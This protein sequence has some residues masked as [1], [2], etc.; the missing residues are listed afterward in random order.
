LRTERSEVE[1]EVTLSTDPKKG[2]DAQVELK[3]VDL[4]E[5]K[6]VAQLPWGGVV[7][8]TGTLKGAYGPE[9]RVEGR[10]SAKD[11]RFHALDI[12]QVETGLVFHR[13]KL[14]FPQASV[15][16]GRSRFAAEGWI[17]F[18]RKE[19]YARARATM[20]GARVADLLQI[21]GDELWLFDHLR[22]RMDGR[23]SGEAVFVEGPM[24]RPTAR[25]NLNLDDATYFERKLGRGELSVRIDDGQTLDI[26]RL[27]F[28]GPSGRLSFTGG[29]RFDE[30]LDFVIDA[31]VLY[32]SELLKPD[33][34][35]LN[36]SGTL[37]GK[38]RLHGTPERPLMDGE[39]DVDELK[40]Y[41]LPFGSGRLTLRM[42]GKDLSLKGPLG[43]DLLLDMRMRNE[44]DLPFAIGATAHTRHLERYLQ[45]VE[46]VH[47]ALQGD[48]LA[49]GTVM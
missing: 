2:L 19:P 13:L 20:E 38:A 44:G 42:D 16:K 27:H 39:V 1:A 36:G 32:V 24:M 30:A 41:G 18:G 43:H 14:E 23:A 21:I 17:D 29:M 34:V 46:G 4:G 33:G 28:N 5:L 40:A 9:I 26:D 48:V 35:E 12:G 45:G 22:G 31:P 49:T 37:S 47:G 10:L 11:L 15:Q 25:I 7:S 8:G 3:Q 6:H